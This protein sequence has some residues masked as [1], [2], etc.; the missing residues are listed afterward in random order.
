MSYNF[1]NVFNELM[2]LVLL[3]VASVIMGIVMLKRREVFGSRIGYVV[4]GARAFTLI[5]AITVVTVVPL[6]VPVIGVILTAIWQFYVG[7]RLLKLGQGSMSTA[8]A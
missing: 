4:V 3:S 6:I 1:L 7:A 5:G 2:A 8:T